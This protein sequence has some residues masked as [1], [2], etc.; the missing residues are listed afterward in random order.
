VPQTPW[1]KPGLSHPFQSIDTL[2]T[3]LV[4][5]LDFSPPIAAICAYTNTTDNVDFAGEINFLAGYDH[6]VFEDDSYGFWYKGMRLGA[7]INEDFGINTTWWNGV[8]LGDPD[9]IIADSP[10]IDGWVNKVNDKVRLDNLSADLFYHRP[11]YTF[12]L[13]RGR[14]QVGN[15]ISGSIILNDRVND[16]GYFIA[17]GRF[18]NLQLS[19]LQGQLMATEPLPLYDDEAYPE[20][21]KKNYP[22]KYIALHRVA[23]TIDQRLEL[24]F[25]ETV[26]YGNRAPDPNYLL[27]QGF[28]RVAEHNLRDRD[29]VMIFGGVEYRTRQRG[30]TCYTNALIDEMRYGE[31]FGNWWGNKYALQTGMQFATGGTTACLEFTAVR[32]WTYTHYLPYGNYTHDGR[33]LGH[34][35]G[36]N[37]LNYS[38]ELSQKLHHGIS[39]V[40]NTSYLR[41]G[42]TG[43]SPDL[44]YIELIEDIDH[45]TADWLQG[46]ITN[47]WEQNT[48]LQIDLF[49]YHRLR[50]SHRASHID[51]W[52]HSI[53]LGWQ[54]IY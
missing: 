3:S 29:N 47:T 20:L 6:A 4:H 52:K 41:Q 44:N 8:F 48:S 32:P 49:A 10:L 46:G 11:S 23:Y 53:Q 27:P 18:G 13:G 19:M 45:T 31:I 14:F 28:W 25:G 43:N 5:V 21:N 2:A 37:L 17:E 24:S 39:F 40:S 9:A 50:I 54:F 12:A 42:A 51:S 30:F 26:V 33:P 36:S 1:F 7:T 38:L 34:P 35:Q 15:S 16:Y 22:E